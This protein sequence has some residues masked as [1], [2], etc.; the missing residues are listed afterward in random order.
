VKLYIKNMVCVRCE[1][2]VKNELSRLGYEMHSIKAG[3]VELKNELQPDEKEK[4]HKVLKKLGLGLLDD[5]KSILVEKIQ[6]HIIE[7]VHYMPDQIKFNLS[8]YLKE[9]LGYDSTYLSRLFAE[10]KGTTIENFYIVQRI[11]RAKELLIY[12]DM[13]LSE[14]AYKLH[15]S[16]TSHFSNQFKKTTGL[17][18][19]YFRQIR[20][21]KIEL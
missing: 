10:V 13:S 15:Y 4:L 11:E 1:S 5:K 14:I 3:E 12:E 8:E 18:P 16:S 7:L 19:A 20:K 9:K 21:E 2:L 6:N 17:T